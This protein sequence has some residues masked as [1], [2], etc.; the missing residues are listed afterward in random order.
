MLL[1]LIPACCESSNFFYFK[2]NWKKRCILI[3]GC[4]SFIPKK[5]VIKMN[6]SEHILVLDTSVLATSFIKLRK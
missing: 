3:Y 2:I 5:H 1:D 4:I 6:I